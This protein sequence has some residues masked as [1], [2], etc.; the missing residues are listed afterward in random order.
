M[1]NVL[2]IA[3]LIG[4]LTT[5]TSCKKYLDIVPVG[6]VIPT[7]VEDFRKELDAA[8]AIN[9]YD[10]GLASYRGD[11]IKMNETRSGDVNQLQPNYLWDEN[12]G[13]NINTYD[14]KNKFQQIFY[15]NHIIGAVPDATEGTTEQKN[16]LL[17]EA[18]LVRAYAYFHLV[19]LYGK[20]YN[21]VTAA[22][23]KAIPLV[24]KV[25]ME[26]VGRRNSVKEVYDQILADIETG[27]ALVNIDQY[28]TAYSYRFSKL[29]GLALAA[30][31]Y[32]YTHQWSKALETAKSVLD[33]KGT[34]IDFNQSSALP[35]LYNSLETIQALEQN[36]TAIQIQTVIVS[37]ALFN[38][39]N[40]DNDL[41]LKVFYKKDSKNNNV[42]AK[43]SSGNNYRQSFRVSEMYLIAAEAAAQLNQLDIARGFL[44]QLK[45]N[46]LTPAFYLVEEARLTTLSGDAF[47][48]EIYD[49]RFRELSFEGHRWFDLRRTTQPQITHILRGKTT[50]L[51]K[52]DPRYTIKIPV[53][54]IANN[55]L[56]SE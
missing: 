7:T 35:T 47:L 32:L 31:V 37:D 24:T 55:P 13:N 34:L 36:Y 14:W 6:K 18:Y 23:D 41:R 5:A 16:Q 50:I 39:Y 33:K 56:L 43:V 42:V 51:Q 53:D 3:G 28:E 48:N 46:R 25:D 52:N 29:S 26:N 2:Y 49:E 9:V 8:Y 30:R 17:G 19:N 4:I 1:R 54:A 15:A 27:L 12:N 21:E 11:E 10:K 38:K 45:K 40:Q 22:S 20:P 44:N